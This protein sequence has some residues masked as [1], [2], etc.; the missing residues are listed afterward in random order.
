MRQLGEGGEIGGTPS[1][2]WA[3][4]PSKLLASLSYSHF[5]ELLPITDPLKRALTR[6]NV[7]GATG[8]SGQHRLCGATLC[9]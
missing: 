3:I 2:E 5:V 7:S 6:S 8:R 4:P 1:P 9:G